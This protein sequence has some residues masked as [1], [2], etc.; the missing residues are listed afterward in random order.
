MVAQGFVCNGEHSQKQVCKDVMNPKIYVVWARS[1][2]AVAV[3][4][5]DCADF[6]AA[7]NRSP[8]PCMSM[9]VAS[10]ACEVRD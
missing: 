9:L 6:K 8:S 2:T 5:A 7:S 1:L 4:N 3:R 10:L